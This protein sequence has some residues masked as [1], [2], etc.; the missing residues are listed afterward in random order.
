MSEFEVMVE[1]LLE[2]LESEFE[3]LRVTALGGGHGL[4]QGLMAILDYADVV[5]AVVTVA[6]D[7]GSSGRLVPGLQIPP[8]GDLRMALLA[9]SPT[10]TLWRDLLDYRFSAADVSGHSLGNL[11]IAALTEM[12][13][14]FEDALNT[15]GRLLGA[16]GAVVP[17]AD[18]P[19]QLEATIDGAVVSGQAAVGAARGRMDELRVLPADAKAPSAAIRAIAQAD[20]V[21]IGPGSLFTSLIACLKVPGIATAINE[22]GATLVYVSNLTTQ[23]GETLGMD[24]ADHLEALML[25]GGIRVP[26]VVVAHDGA[27]HVPLPVRPVTVDLGRMAELGTSVEVTDIADPSADW[28]QHHPARL[29]AVLRR[30]A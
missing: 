19:L 8:P 11:I 22:T 28:P 25:H 15:V 17:A 7:G 30:L 4:A 5:T 29:G 13:G 12:S 21:V 10:P 6:D 20:Q 1:P 24:A 23:D 16:R 26:D 2:E 14:D 3:G 18:Q 27:V 9:L